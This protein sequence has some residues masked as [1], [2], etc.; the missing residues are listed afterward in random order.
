MTPCTSG[1]I[2]SYDYDADR[3]RFKVLYRYGAL[4]EYRG[5]PMKVFEGFLQ[6]ESKG[7]YHR[8]NVVNKYDSEKI[9]G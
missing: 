8:A 6:A 3:E 2:E 1:L 9:G 4:W 5:V 7:K